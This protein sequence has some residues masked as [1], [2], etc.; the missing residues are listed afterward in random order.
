M[1][2]RADGVRVL[3][4]TGVHG[5][6]AV[7][8]TDGSGPV[9]R[10]AERCVVVDYIV[11]S[12]YIEVVSGSARRLVES[13]CA[14]SLKGA[15]AMAS[16]RKNELVVVSGASTGIGAATARELASMGYHVL[17]G[18][19]T[20]REA[21]AVRGAGVEPVTLDITVPEHVDALA[22]R[23]AGDP[24]GR[25]LR[26][27]VNNAGIE[28][29]APVE[30]LPLDV[31]REQF[32][33]NLFGHIAVIQKL[34]PYLRRS[35]G[36]IVNISSV[37][38]V[39]ALPIFGAYAGT[40]F[41]LEAASDALRRE[42]RAQGVQVVVV[43]PGGVRTEMAARSGDVSL[44]LA[45]RMS[46][47]HRRLYGALVESTVA[48]NAAFLKR[49][50]PAAKAGAKVARVVTVARPR[51]RYTLG[52]DAAFTIPLARFLP[53]RL[54]DRVLTPGRRRAG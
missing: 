18:V 29:N 35:R 14:S 1:N 25:A 24:E 17:A 49:A 6:S 42:V 30:V 15:T 23:I 46:A 12:I 44:E 39:A 31:W 21:D 34:L 28:V 33:V 32:E 47:E 51:T 36:R 26:A 54:L 53:D 4:G 8:F 3:P 16:A 10:F 22:E 13:A 11:C 50:V 41:A 45:G 7:L 2:D 27:L 9:S 19:R 52:T 20:D 5:R 48:S 38:G 37:G 43:Q 40:K